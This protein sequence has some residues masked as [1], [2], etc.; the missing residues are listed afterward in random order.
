MPTVVFHKNG[1]THQGEVK[2]NTNLVV[3]AGI[4]QFPF[5]HLRYECGMGKCSKCACRVMSGAQYLPE[6][7]WKEK[8]QLGERLAQGYRLACQLW[9]EHDIELA[10]DDLEQAA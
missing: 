6:P 7:N 10:Q 9:I 8:K 3:R 2:E 1:A 5:P 4:R